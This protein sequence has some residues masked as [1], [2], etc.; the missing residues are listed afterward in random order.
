MRVLSELPSLEVLRAQALALFNMPAQQLVRV[1][2]AVPQGVV[3][4]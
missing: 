3:N 2:N 4:V 1:Y